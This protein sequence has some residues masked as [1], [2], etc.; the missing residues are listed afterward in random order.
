MVD[1]GCSSFRRRLTKGIRRLDVVITSPP[2]AT[3]QQAMPPVTSAR[4]TVMREL[5]AASAAVADA[6]SVATPS[7]SAGSEAAG[8]SV[9]LDAAASAAPAATAAG[10]H[11]GPAPQEQV[12]GGGVEHAGASCG[13]ARGGAPY[14]T[15]PT[16][17]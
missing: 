4:D 15:S 6:T 9:D 16:M 13:L 12:T 3:A 10:A 1:G 8:T 5:L 17:G 7:A 11:G 14:S 2:T